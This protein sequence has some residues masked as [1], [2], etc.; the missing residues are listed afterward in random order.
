MICQE[1]YHLIDSFVY[2]I[3]LSTCYVISEIAVTASLI[4]WHSYNDDDAEIDKI[5][6]PEKNQS[7]LDKIFNIEAKEVI[8]GAKF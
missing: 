3:L 7:Q 6:R 8:M 2:N 4:L 1:K 5:L